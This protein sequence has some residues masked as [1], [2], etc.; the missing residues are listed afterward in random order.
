MQLSTRR[1]LAARTLDQ[2]LKDRNEISSAVRDD[3]REEAALY[4]IEVSR[5]DVK[6][7]VFP[8]ACV[9]S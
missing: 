6:D 1:F 7:L 2:I 9:R 5:A 8:V 4:G 3:M